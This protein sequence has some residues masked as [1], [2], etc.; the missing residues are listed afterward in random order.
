MMRIRTIIL[1]V[2]PLLAIS[3]VRAGPDQE[4]IRFARSPDISPDGEKSLRAALGSDFDITKPG[5]EFLQFIAERNATLRELLASERKDDLKKW[6]WGREI[7]DLLR[8]TPDANCSPAEFISLLKKLAPRS[9]SISSSPKTHDGQVHLTINIVR[10]ASHGRARKGIASTF[11][12]DRAGGLS[13][14]ARHLGARLHQRPRA[15]ALRAE[16]LG[17]QR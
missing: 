16:P 17:P 13:L 10:Y 12:A 14:R 1:A 9:Y 8:A 6:L 11:L 2:I 15:V 5:P 3:P 4:P 7:I